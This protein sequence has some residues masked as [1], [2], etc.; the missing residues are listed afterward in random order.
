MTVKDVTDSEMDFVNCSFITTE[1][2]IAAKEGNS[3]PQKGDVLFSKDGT[4]GKVHV[5]TTNRP[6]AVLSSLAILRPKKRIQL[7][8]CILD[9]FYAH[10]QCLKMH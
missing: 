4:V 1:D 5:V 10:L 9:M 8:L 2:Y 7:T 3:A 6:F